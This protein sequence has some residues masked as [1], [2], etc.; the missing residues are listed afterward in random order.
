MMS[1]SSE[2]G[3]GEAMRSRRSYSAGPQSDSDEAALARRKSSLSA[4]VLDFDVEDDK[5]VM[6]RG[7]ERLLC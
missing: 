5:E 1:S 2:V 6:N 3:E 7:S 4:E